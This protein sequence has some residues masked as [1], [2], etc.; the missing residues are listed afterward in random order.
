MVRKERPPGLRPGSRAAAQIARDGAF[1]NGEAEFQ[2]FAVDPRRTPETIL[3]CQSPN[4]ISSGRIDARSSR[5]SRATVP[6]SAYAF[7]MPPIDGGWLNQQQRIPAI[8]ASTIAKIA[9]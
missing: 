9:T 7:A 8:G 3:C 2:Q 1:R 6:A 4:Q 5:T